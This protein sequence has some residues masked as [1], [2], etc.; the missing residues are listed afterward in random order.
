MQETLRVRVG[1]RVEIVLIHENDE[2][3]PLTLDIVNDAVADFE[4][5]LLGASTSLAKAIVGA[6]G[7]DVI[8]YRVG[9][10]SAVR[11]M[12]VTRSPSDLDHSAS[13]RRQQVIDRAV[14][15]SDRTNALNFASSFSSK[16]GGYEPEGIE[17]W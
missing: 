12:T 4:Q 8:D 1:R 3:E 5:G 13:E 6:R 14:S 15:E 7:G 2:E 17:D 9:D 11:V 10:L 16:W